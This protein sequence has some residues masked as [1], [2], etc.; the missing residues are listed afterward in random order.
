MYSNYQSLS[1]KKNECLIE[2]AIYQNQEIYKANKNEFRFKIENNLQINPPSN[3]IHISNIK[4]EYFKEEF[5]R[6]LFEKFGNI[7]NIK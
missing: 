7:V 6:G 4:P 5:I 1:I 3:V 2:K